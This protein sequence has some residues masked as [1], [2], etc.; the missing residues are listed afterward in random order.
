MKIEPCQY[1]C[2]ALS[3][4]FDHG[5][6]LLGPYCW[7]L[8][9]QPDRPRITIFLTRKQ[10]RKAQETCC[11]RKTRVERVYVTIEVAKNDS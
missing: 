4:K 9:E 5:R 3:S 8:G 2:W 10:A 6:L 7:P 1:V 11:Y